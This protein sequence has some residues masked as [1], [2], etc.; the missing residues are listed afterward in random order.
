MVD[1]DKLTKD[2]IAKGGILAVLYFDLHGSSKEVLQELA[3]GFVQKILKEPGVIY[4]L[5]EI[6]EP[7]K[8]K[9]DKFFSTSVEVK[10]L[11]TGFFHMFR[12]CMSYSPFSLE[13]LRPDAIKLTIDQA[14]EVLMDSSMTAFEYKKHIIEKMS[15]KEQL[16][17]YRKTV[18]QKIELGKKLSEKKG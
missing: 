8:A 3:S 1:V 12:I 4:A 16:D 2:T 9:D 17:T 13:I 5:G 6:D 18:E 7:L 14:H 11:T 10:L 15:T